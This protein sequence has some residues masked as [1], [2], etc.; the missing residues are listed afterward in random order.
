[1]EARIL[2]NDPRGLRTGIFVSLPPSR[3]GQRT[4]FAIPV[5]SSCLVC[6]HPL[7]DGNVKQTCSLSEILDLCRCKFERLGGQTSHTLGRN[8]LIFR[9]WNAQ[10]IFRVKCTRD[11][12][13]VHHF[14]KSVGLLSEVP[15][16]FVCFRTKISGRVTRLLGSYSPFTPPCA[17]FMLRL[18]SRA[19]ARTTFCP[20]D[21]RSD[22]FGPKRTRRVSL[23]SHP[24]L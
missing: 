21:P 5:V 2:E 12:N 17:N 16:C 9:V 20:L 22:P 7:P 10:S 23:S 6:L 13:S 4:E 15:D 18:C 14:G 24:L 8:G 3:S 19:C 1:M 11:K